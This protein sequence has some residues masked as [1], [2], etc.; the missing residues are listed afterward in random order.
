VHNPASGR[1]DQLWKIDSMTSALVSSAEYE[2]VGAYLVKYNAFDSGSQDFSSLL[3][4]ISDTHSSKTKI[5]V[6]ALVHTLAICVCSLFAAG[7]AQTADRDR[8][9][10]VH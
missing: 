10:N 1:P 8:P 6:R 3:G 2:D 7:A 4:C 5:V 9:N